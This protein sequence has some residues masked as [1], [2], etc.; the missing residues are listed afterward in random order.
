MAICTLSL[1]IAVHIM[2]LC[3][4]DYNVSA[5]FTNGLAGNDSVLP[6]VSI[7]LL[8]NTIGGRPCLI[9]FELSN[10]STFLF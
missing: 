10:F 9:I 4:L 7:D 3:N 1:S 6:D 8:V 5:N 2:V